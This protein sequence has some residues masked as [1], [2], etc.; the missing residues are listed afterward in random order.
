[1]TWDSTRF[2]NHGAEIEAAM[3]EDAILRLEAK[4]DEQRQW[5]DRMTAS[6]V[7]KLR[8]PGGLDAN[9]DPILCK[10]NDEAVFARI[11]AR[12]HHPY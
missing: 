1:M 4:R 12:A 3:R 7:K 2:L 9:G 10:A 6:G 11:D 8:W 5:I